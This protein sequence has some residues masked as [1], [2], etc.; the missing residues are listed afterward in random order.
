MTGLAFFL[1][2]LDDDEDG[3]DDA[4]SNAGDIRAD[5]WEKTF[6]NIRGKDEL[7]A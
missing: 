6:R 1:A 2:M 7:L 3:N 4:D 5:C